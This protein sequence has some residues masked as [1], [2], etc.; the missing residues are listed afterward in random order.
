MIKLPVYD[1]I[2]DDKKMVRLNEID[3]IEISKDT[4]VNNPAAVYNLLETYFKLSEKPEEYMYMIGVKGKS[5]PV[6]IFNLSHGGIDIT[7][8]NMRGV[9]IRALLTNSKG[10]ILCHNHPSGTKEFSDYDVNVYKR[11]KELCS[12]ME[13]DLFDFIVVANNDYISI[14]DYIKD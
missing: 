11:M 6:G 5:K 9:F 3:N 8:V 7:Y 12:W 10:I 2:Y 1:L 13:M 14:N 4:K